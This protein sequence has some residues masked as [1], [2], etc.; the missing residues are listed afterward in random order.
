METFGRNEVT[1]ND[2]VAVLNVHKRRAEARKKSCQPFNLMSSRKRHVRLRR[3]GYHV[4][5]PVIRR[6]A[7]RA[8]IQRMYAEVNDEVRKVLRE[9]LQLV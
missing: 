4:R 2:V 5:R 9:R 1:E 7:Q 8:G 3:M 6:L